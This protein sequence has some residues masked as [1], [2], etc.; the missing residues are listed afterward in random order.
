MPVVTVPG[1]IRFHVNGETLNAFHVPRAHTDGD[2]IVHFT[3]SD[4][5]HMGDVFF[6]G[7]YP[8]IDGGSGGTPEGVIAAY[9]R[10]LAL[11]GEKTK[12]IPGHGPIVDK[13]AV[14]AHRDMALAVQTKVAAL[15]KQGKTA[16]EIVA[17]KV[18][19]DTDAKVD[20]TGNSNERFVRALVTE[21][22]AAR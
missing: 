8:F 4:V 5:V 17:A 2:L 18:T 13:N 20:P 22:S 6:N 10:V 14:A 19:A 12:I 21:Q 7:W 11:A 16:D 9:D 15:V 3:G 1:D